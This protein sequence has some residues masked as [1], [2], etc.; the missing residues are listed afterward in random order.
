MDEI[1]AIEEA[2]KAELDVVCLLLSYYHIRL[3][4]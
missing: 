1:R 2:T 3:T 4:K